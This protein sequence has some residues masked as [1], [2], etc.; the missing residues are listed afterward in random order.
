MNTGFY[1]WK[2]LAAL[3]AILII[4]IAF[5]FYG[6]SVINTYMAVE[7]NLDRKILGLIFTAFTLMSGLSAPLAALIINRAGVRF[8]IIM[9]CVLIC[10]G[11]M[12][13]A[14]FITTGIQA[15]LTY[16]ILVG[17]GVVSGGALTA[18]AAVANWFVL[19][20]ALALSLVLSAPGIGG[21]VVA[22][23]VNHVITAAG[24]NW[25]IGWWLIAGLS[26]MALLIAALFVKNRP[27][28]IGQFPDGAS[29]DREDEDDDDNTSTAVQPVYRT[30][31]KWIFSEAIRQPVLWLVMLCS[32]GF[33]ST[34]VLFQAHGVIHIQDLG[35]TPEAAARSISILAIST[36]VGNFIIGALGDRIDPK[37]L[38]MMTLSC[39][40]LSMLLAS[41][42]TSGLG[43]Y[44]FV[45]LLGIG[46]GG[47]V[48]CVMTL[49]GNYFGT[50]IYASV[51]G[52]N[53][54]AQTIGSSSVPTL[55]GWI[56]DHYGS[57]NVIFYSLA[58]LC[59]TGM[60]LLILS[61]PPVRGQLT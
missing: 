32:V 44:T 14:L 37:Y 57:Y 1:G 35:N 30:K 8:T 52:C 42:A 26:C 45:V 55:A 50:G 4:N 34:F 61:R 21:F 29:S 22:P 28:D 25:R 9:G 10:I 27:G 23:L 7:F 38:L 43:I 20:R 54:A 40:V 39:S 18:Q 41:Q 2:L 60:V 47:S 5:P 36:L 12:T 58:G 15:V 59:L 11:T 13:M 6:A 19:K 16:G 49:L 3:W 33:G 51:V 46:F 53:L 24:G 56:Y 17:A 31:E 48:I